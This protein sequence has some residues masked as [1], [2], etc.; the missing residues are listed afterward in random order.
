MQSKE[1]RLKGYYSQEAGRRISAAMREKAE[2]GIMPG[3][4]PLGY[5]NAWVDGQK[6]IAIDPETAPKVKRLFELAG[7][8]KWSLRK[9]AA[10]ADR[11]GLKTRNSKAFGL[12]S[13]KAVIENPFYLGYMR[14]NDTIIIGQHSSLVSAKAF[15]AVQSNLAARRRR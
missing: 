6:T 7:R 15:Q 12:S 1:E 3:C 11:M 8:K 10:E 4:A 9:L 13:L 5:K 2:R 14:Y